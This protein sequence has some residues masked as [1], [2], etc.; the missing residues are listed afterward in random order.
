MFFEILLWMRKS[1]DGISV[2]TVYESSNMSWSILGT[3]SPK[4]LSGK[5]NGGVH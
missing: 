1:F 3:N 2:K 5:K 4:L